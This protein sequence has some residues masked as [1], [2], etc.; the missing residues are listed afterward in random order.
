MNTVGNNIYPVLSNPSGAPGMASLSF[1]N[2]LPSPAYP[3]YQS[4][5]LWLCFDSWSLIPG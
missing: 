4:W 1:S 2:S 3:I 5:P